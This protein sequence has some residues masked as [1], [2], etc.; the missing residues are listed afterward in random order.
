MRISVK[1]KYALAA[2]IILAKQYSSEN[3]VSTVSIAENLNISKIY[4]EQVFVLLKKS[5][6]VASAKGTQGGYRLMKP[7]LQVTVYDILSAVELS[8]FEPAGDLSDRP[9]IN[10]VLQM[11]VFGKLDDAVKNTLGETTLAKLVEEI[12]K[13]TNSQELMFYI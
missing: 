8:L 5:G 3:Y 11:L 1:S 7:P 12:A 4:L 10:E 2:A 13:H 9:E 6:V